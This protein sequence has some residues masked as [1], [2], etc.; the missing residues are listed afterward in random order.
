VTGPESARGSAVL[1]PV[2]Q[3]MSSSIPPCTNNCCGREALASTTGAV[4]EDSI[5]IAAPRMRVCVRLRCRRPAG[6][7]IHPCQ[8]ATKKLTGDN[9]IQ[10]Y[11]HRETAA[12]EPNHSSHQ[13]THCA[14]GNAPLAS[15]PPHDSVAHCVLNTYLLVCPGARFVRASP[16]VVYLVC[17]TR[18][19]RH[20]VGAV[21]DGVCRCDR[22]SFGTMW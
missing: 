18:S 8:S 7:K 20:E 11:S 14:C 4:Q 13:H 17:F 9:F 16:V 12:R 22:G 21:V 19:G 5:P 15:F 1:S 6:R 2:H 10:H 3:G